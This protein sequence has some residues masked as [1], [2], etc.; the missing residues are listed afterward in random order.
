M[1]D[2]E[3][4]KVEEIHLRKQ[5]RNTLENDAELMEALCE[6]DQLDENEIAPE[7]FEDGFS[8][9]QAVANLRSDFNEWKAAHAALWKAIKK[10]A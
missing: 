2:I 1:S 9:E 5:L 10:A 3:E 4:L 8:G 6:L 7:E